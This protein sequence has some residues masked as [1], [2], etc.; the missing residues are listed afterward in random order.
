MTD[1]W[2]PERVKAL[3]VRTDVETAGSIFG[4]SRTQSYEAVNAGRF[5]VPTFRIGRR[6]VVPVA[7]ILALLRIN[8]TSL[9]LPNAADVG[10][11]TP[12]AEP[13]VSDGRRARV[14]AMRS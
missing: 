12:T 10:E 2:S 4:L 9:E 1:V 6:V 5:P 7:P 11:Q 8:T 14:H 3:G 13:D